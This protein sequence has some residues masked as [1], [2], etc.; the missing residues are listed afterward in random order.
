MLLCLALLSLFLSFSDVIMFLTFET[1]AAGVEMMGKHSH[2]SLSCFLSS[3]LVCMSGHLVGGW[4]FE[5]W[6]T[7]GMLTMEKVGSG[8][9]WGVGV[10]P[11]MKFWVG[12]S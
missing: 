12:A 6:V 11:L 10:F 7:D 1:Y 2:T 3:L 4:S 9:F 8:W 5:V